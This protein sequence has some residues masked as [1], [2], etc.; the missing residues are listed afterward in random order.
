MHNHFNC[1]YFTPGSCRPIQQPP[2][3]G[4]YWPDC[5]FPGNPCACQKSSESDAADPDS[6]HQQNGSCLIT[7]DLNVGA[8]LTVGGA[9]HLKG[10]L[11]VDGKIISPQDDVNPSGGDDTTTPDDGP[12]GIA[13][14][15]STIDVSGD[16]ITVS[17]TT[18]DG[19]RLIRLADVKKIDSN[20]MGT[21][22][23][24][25]AAMPS[26]SGTEQS[27]RYK[28]YNDVTAGNNG[29]DVITLAPGSKLE[30]AGGVPGKAYGGQGVQ[31]TVEGGELS[32]V[33]S[34]DIGMIQDGALPSG[35][36]RAQ[37]GAHNADV[38]RMVAASRWN[39]ILDGMYY[40]DLG[41]KT[42]ATRDILLNKAVVLRR[43]LRIKGGGLTAAR[44]LFCV[45]AGGGLV[46]E[47]VVLDN[48]R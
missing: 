15:Q 45:E 19:A 2:Y 14:E 3:S 24:T 10:D 1:P 28:L 32:W 25:S 41:I 44:Y 39:L 4:F 48:I 38:L 13:P 11:I 22:H 8:D 12:G 21:T 33:H 17:A 30:P 31:I 18:V 46:M 36:T 37:V 40:V 23:V 6:A 5:P 29:A 27:M 16:G 7:N 43:P 20:S 42:G 47:D 26:G 34:S 9:T 35:M